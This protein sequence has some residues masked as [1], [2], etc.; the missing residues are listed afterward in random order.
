MLSLDHTAGD[1]DRCPNFKTLFLSGG[2]RVV[3][4]CGG[5]MTIYS[6]VFPLRFQSPMCAVII[7]AAASALCCRPIASTKSPS[8][9]IER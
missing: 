5:V 1:Y 3:L 4:R 7:R 2:G 8:G 6:D 9:S